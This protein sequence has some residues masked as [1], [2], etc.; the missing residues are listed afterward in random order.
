MCSWVIILCSYPNSEINWP[1][2]SLVKHELEEWSE[3]VILKNAFIR[4]ST[5]LLQGKHAK[6]CISALHVTLRAADSIAG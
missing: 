4:G 6:L 2:T 1:N 5:T 3:E